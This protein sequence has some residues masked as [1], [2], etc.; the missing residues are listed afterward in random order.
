MI[1]FLKALPELALPPTLRRASE[2]WKPLSFLF[3]SEGPSVD[4]IWVLMGG[5]PLMEGGVRGGSGCLLSSSPFFERTLKNLT[6]DVTEEM[7]I[8]NVRRKKGISKL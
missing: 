5:D 7:E 1:R 2:E 6:Y 3:L 4:H 8:K